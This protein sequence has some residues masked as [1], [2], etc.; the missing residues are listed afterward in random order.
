MRIRSFYNR[1]L[2]LRR[3]KLTEMVI[4]N[5]T[6]FVNVVSFRIRSHEKFNKMYP[7]TRIACLYFDGYSG[8]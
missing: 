3:D 5:E 8:Q 2:K 7:V 1:S 4:D 6:I